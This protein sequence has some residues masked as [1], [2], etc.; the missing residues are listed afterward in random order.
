MPRPVHLAGQRL[1]RRPDKRDAG[2]RPSGRRIPRPAASGRTRSLSV[3]RPLPTETASLGFGGSP[4]EG[5]DK[6]SR[7]MF[8]TFLCGRYHYPPAAVAVSE[9]LGAGFISAE[10]T[11]F[12][13]WVLCADERAV[14]SCTQRFFGVPAWGWYHYSRRALHA[15]ETLDAQEL[16]RLI[17]RFCNAAMFALRGRSSPRRVHTPPQS[18]TAH[19]AAHRAK[20]GGFSGSMVTMF[21][22]VRSSTPSALFRQIRRSPLLLRKDTVIPF[23]LR[24]STL[25]RIR[26]EKLL[27]VSPSVPAGAIFSNSALAGALISGCWRS[28]SERRKR[29]R[30][31]GC[32]VCSQLSDSNFQT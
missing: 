20:H 2:R 8:F 22:V 6:N 26:W 3:A 13:E 28:S 27:G 15:V 30:S 17:C 32:S 7:V 5:G 24:V 14:P 1:R 19:T 31:L 18:L 11:A 10:K 23:L 4:V 29:I 12:S 16:R 9:Q 21:S 25:L